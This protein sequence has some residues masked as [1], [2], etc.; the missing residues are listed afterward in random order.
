MP[1]MDQTFRTHENNGAAYERIAKAISYVTNRAGSQPTLEEMAAHI[2]MSPFHFQRLFSRWAGVTPKKYLQVLTVERAKKLLHDDRPMLEVSGA[3]GLSSGS[4]LHDHFV[5]LEAVTPGE[6]KNAGVGLTIEHGIHD[7]PFGKAFIAITT[8]GV[9]KFSFLDSDGA[10]HELAD[11][12]KSWPGARF[13][14]SS[15]KTLAVA[16]AMFSTGK[17]PDR[18]LSLLVSGTNFQVS[19]WKALLRIPPARVTSYS[20]L[21]SSIGRPAAARAVG[22]AV[23]AN[24]I[25]FFIPCHRVIQQSGGLGGY[26]WGETRKQAMY[27]WEAARFDEGGTG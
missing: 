12:M 6:Y 15:E 19:V 7:T 21:A 27:A 10:D 2:H 24:P 22:L 23:G 11:L 14:M 17:R 26:R 25:A 8:R 1:H 13:A 5:A 9:C 16:E 18:P 3:V 4:R 20:Q